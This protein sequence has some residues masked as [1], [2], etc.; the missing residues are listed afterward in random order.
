MIV[1]SLEYH[2]MMQF[3]R[4]LLGVSLLSADILT[5]DLLSISGNPSPFTITSATAGQNPSPVVNNSTT[6]TVN[7]LTV[8][9]SITGSLN[10]NMPSGVTLSVQLQASTGATSSGS[11]A[12]STVA[13]TLVSNIKKNTVQ[14]GLT[15]TYTFAAT[16][17]ASPVTNG[18]K[19]LTLTL[20]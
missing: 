8:I 16:A 11:V 5:A 19:T 12:M 14:A 17:A 18:T 6:Y 10:T 7:T 4:L 9:R 2:S 3:V 13:N 1:P 15:I 20:Q